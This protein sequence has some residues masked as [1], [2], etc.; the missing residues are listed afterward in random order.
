MTVDLVVAP[1]L[2]LPDNGTFTVT[3]TPEASCVFA[4]TSGGASLTPVPPTV[5][6]DKFGVGAEDWGLDWGAV[7]AQVTAK[8]TCTELGA[9]GR[10]AHGNATV[11][12][13]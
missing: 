3:S 11:T 5:A 2:L 12:W 4:T 7:G 8:V 13:P 6:L 10:I 1:P 9:H